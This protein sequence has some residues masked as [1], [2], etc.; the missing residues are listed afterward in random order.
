MLPYFL[1]LIYNFNSAPL[2]EIQDVLG[3]FEMHS[4]LLLFAFYK[5]SAIAAPTNVGEPLSLPKFET[6]LVLTLS[7][8]ELPSLV[9]H[10]S[11][12]S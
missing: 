8:T 9:F 12:L 5:A 11:H 1:S 2:L 4:A 3:W 7:R 6:E 10:F